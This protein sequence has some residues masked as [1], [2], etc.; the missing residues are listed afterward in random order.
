MQSASSVGRTIGTPI[1]CAVL[2]FG[3]KSGLMVDGDEMCV[4][5]GESVGRTNL[6]AVLAD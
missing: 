5:L 2:F 3:H 4:K 6:D 1:L